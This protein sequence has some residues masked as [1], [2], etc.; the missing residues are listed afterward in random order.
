MSQTQQSAL[1]SSIYDSD[2]DN[3]TQNH[4]FTPDLSESQEILPSFE[5]DFLRPS[6]P[7]S[8][9]LTFTRISPSRTKVY[10]LY[11]EM[12]HNDQITQWLETGF[13]KKQHIHQD[14][15]HQSS[16]QDIFHQIAH[17]SDSTTKVI[18][19]RYRQILKHPNFIR[20]TRDRKKQRQGTSTIKSHL[21]SAGYIKATQGQGTDITRFLQLK[22]C[23]QSIIIISSSLITR[24]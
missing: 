9:P 24:L 4:P 23:F 15:K 16:T 22:V 10:F 8:I 13:G 18:C 5:T 20:K 11:D 14:A 1:S 17:S 6:L 3:Y 12:L 21:S 7:P 2:F 19:K